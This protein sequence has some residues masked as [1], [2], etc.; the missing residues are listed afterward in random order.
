MKENKKKE[1]TLSKAEIQRKEAFEQLAARLSG[2][3][4]T[5]KLIGIS[6]SEMNTKAYLVTIPLMIPFLI[7]YFVLGH[8]LELDIIPFLISIAVFFVLIVVHEALHGV[9]WSV[10]AKSK[11]KSISF[12]VIMESFTPYCNCNEPLKKHQLITGSLAPTVIL[13]VGFGIAALLTG[14]TLLLFIAFWNILGCAGDLMV[15]WKLLSYQS[16]ASDILF[17]DHPYEIGTAVFEK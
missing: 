12:G 4:Y 13:G 1:R 17:I 15:V 3:G 16:A 9:V 2:A 10:F 5:Q 6:Q 11:W 14:S 7:L 8:S